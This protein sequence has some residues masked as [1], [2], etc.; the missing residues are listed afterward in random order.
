[1]KGTYELTRTCGRRN[2]TYIALFFVTG[3]HRANGFTVKF[4]ASLRLGNETR[5]CRRGTGRSL[6]FWT[7]SIV[8]YPKKFMDNDRFCNDVEKKMDEE[9]LRTRKLVQ[10]GGASVGC[11]AATPTLP[12]RLCIHVCCLAEC[13]R[14]A[15]YVA[16]STSPRLG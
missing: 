13:H 5:P 3:E 10:A 4:P 9:M 14:T 6:Y 12:H 16:S 1:M 7:Q 15:T 8:P 11:T 2:C